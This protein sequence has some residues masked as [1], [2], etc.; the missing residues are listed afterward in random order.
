M[1]YKYISYTFF[2]IIIGLLLNTSVQFILAW[3]PPSASAPANNT[4]PPLTAGIGTSF[5]SRDTGLGLTGSVNVA[6]AGAQDNKITAPK[7]CLN[8]DGSNSNC[9][10]SWPGGSLSSYN[11]LPAGAMAGY[12]NNIQGDNTLRSPAVQA[13]WGNCTCEA[14]WTSFVTGVAG[15][16]GPGPTT[17]KH[18]SCIKN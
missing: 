10:T 7:Y 14:G 2:G 1:N 13:G 16:T 18:F 4:L 3:S 12:C 8:N 15:G 11:S 6:N 17:Y 9:I 5:Q